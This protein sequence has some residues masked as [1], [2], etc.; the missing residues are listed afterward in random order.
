[1]KIEGHRALISYEG[2]PMTC[3]LCSEQGHQINDCPW[4]KL[5][6]SQQTSHDRSSWANRIKRGT[7]KAPSGVNNGTNNIPL[8]STGEACQ[9]IEPQSRSPDPM[10]VEHHPCPLADVEES[11]SD[12]MNKTDNIIKMAEELISVP[13]DTQE[14]C[15]SATKWSDLLT[16]E[17]DTERDHNKQG[18]KREKSKQNKR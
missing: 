14:T 8:S 15:H 18:K 3:Y 7:E 4:R 1:M 2:Q 10:I 13:T 11:P 17:S 9:V 16:T 12:T 6:G 5:P